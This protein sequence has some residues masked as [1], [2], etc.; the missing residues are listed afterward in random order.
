MAKKYLVAVSSGPDSMYL[1]H[2]YKRV[3][4]AVCFVNYHD[5]EDTDND[6]MIIKNYC[7]KYN[8]KLYILDTNEV[9]LSQ[10][11]SISNKQ[12]YYR[13]IRYDFFLDIAK[14]TNTYKILIGHHKNDFLET[15]FLNLNRQ[16]L[17]YGL[18]K[19]SNYKQLILIRPLLNYWKQDLLDKCVKK[20]IHVVIDYTNFSEM[21]Q[22]N[23]VRKKLET[24]YSKFAL[25]KLYFK[26]RLKN[27]FLNFYKHYLLISFNLWKKANYD[28]SFFLKLNRTK[29]V[30]LL[31]YYLTNNNL[32]VSKT[33]LENVLTFLAKNK[34]PTKTYRLKKDCF[35]NLINKKLN[36]VY[37]SN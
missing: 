25:N 35:L 8:L 20:N 10:Y 36:L 33:K 26:L 13:Q 14:K 37:E 19:K 4:K 9:D 12:D 21:Y 1:L 16:M 17:S 18:L 29:Q 24:N 5:R 7:E 28:L 3:T 6:M 2:K 31:N 11:E 27:F 23:I 22:R 15:Y 32:K 30:Y 34:N